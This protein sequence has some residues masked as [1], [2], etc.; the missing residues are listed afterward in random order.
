MDMPMLGEIT[1]G[2]GE[3][4]EDRFVIK[5]ISAAQ[6]AAEKVLDGVQR[7]AEIE[8]H[9]KKLKDKVDQ[10][11]QDEV[12]KATDS[13]RHLQSVLRDWAANEL[14]G[15]SKTVTLP[16]AKLRFRTTPDRV[17]FD[18]EAQVVAWCEEHQ[19]DVVKVKKLVE[20]RDVKWLLEN[21]DVP[22]VHIEEGIERFYVEAVD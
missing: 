12:E 10:W 20:K 22:G 15:K 19:P 18:D 11:K 6:W 9:A 17:E 13:T 7:I 3:V 8:A 16:Y 2:D 4:E 21:H 14:T 1:M 5:D